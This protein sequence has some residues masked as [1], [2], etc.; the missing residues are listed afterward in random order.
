MTVLVLF[1]LPASARG[2]QWQDKPEIGRLFEKA[3]AVGTF[4]VFDCKAGRLTGHDR[5]RAE[6]RFLPASTFKIPNS[7]I[8]LSAGA[9]ADVDEP[10]PY[11]GRP[12]M[13]KAWEKDMGLR[14]A[15]RISNVPIYQELARRIGLE[16]MRSELQ[17]LNYGNGD[18][19]SQVDSFWL[20]GP[21]GI[22]AAEQVSFLSR[23][24][25]GELPL[26]REAQ[27]A[28]REILLLESGPGWS[29]Y[30][31]TG[32]A[33]RDGCGIGWWVGW[34]EKGDEVYPFAI[35]LDIRNLD[36]DGPKRTALP[37]AALK[38]LG[39]ME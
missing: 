21:L 1:V 28:V 7:L 6:T 36:A 15:I 14:E 22:S 4:V 33:L 38:L 30:A 26:P 13:M 10:L 11:G 18:V 12:Q 20:E 27:A 3:G 39:L 25:K 24:A 29:L 9:V 37:R 31:K 17:R 2:Q 16:R 23:L 8:G 5:I 19:G 34:L 32:A 35:N